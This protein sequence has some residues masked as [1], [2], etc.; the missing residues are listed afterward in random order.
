NNL[1]VALPRCAGLRHGGAH[2]FD[3]EGLLPQCLVNAVLRTVILRL[4]VIDKLAIGIYLAAQQVGI[5]R[6]QGIGDVLDAHEYIAV[7][8]RRGRR[9]DRHRQRDADEEQIERQRAEQQPARGEAR[10]RRSVLGNGHGRAPVSASG[11]NTNE[12]RSVLLATVKPASA[13]SM[14]RS[15]PVMP[16]TKPSAAQP[17]RAA[18]RGQAGAYCQSSSTLGRRHSGIFCRGS[19]PPR[20]LSTRSTAASSV[21]GALALRLSAASRKS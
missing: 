4:C 10:Y 1:I 6:W 18:T 9:T 12:P 2:G 15:S 8:C 17:A 13:G 5:G 11:S 16:S 19:G 14:R 7:P 3:I 21:C 20:R